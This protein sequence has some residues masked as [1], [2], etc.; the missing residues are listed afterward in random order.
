MPT[1]ARKSLGVVLILT[2]VVLIALAAWLGAMSLRDNIR[3]DLR[4]DGLTL[5]AQQEAAVEAWVDQFRPVAPVLAR[6]PRIVAMIADPTPVQVDAMNRE[7]EAITSLAGVDVTYILD[8][9]GTTLASSNWDR[10]VSF[11]GSNF[12]FRPYY[13]AAMQGR[14][15]R[16]FAV[17]TTSGERGYYLA[18][19]VRRQGRVIGAVVL[20]VP[21][22][23]LEQTMRLSEAPVFVSDGNGVIILAGD[24]RLRLTRLRDLTEAETD[25]IRQS[26]QYD[27]AALQPAAIVPEGRWFTGGDIVRTGQGGPRTEAGRFLWLKQPLAAEGWVLNILIDTAP[28]AR[29]LWGAAVIAGAVA[30]AVAAV[31]FVI[32]QRRRRLIAFSRA[33]ESQV[34]DRTALLSAEIA[35]RKATEQM[36]RR[37]QGELVQAGKLAALGQMSAA[38]SHEFNQPLTAIRTYAEN[39]TAF[40]E[41]GSRERATENLSRVMR[42]TER[43][44]QLSRHLTRFAR[45]S[46]DATSVVNLDEVIAEALGLLEGRIVRSEALVAVGG[47][48]G[49]TVWGGTVRLQHV[50]MNLVANAID[51]AGDAVPEIRITVQDAGEA[52]TLTVEDNGPGIPPEV[53]PQVFEPFFTT[54]EVGKGLGLGLSISYNIVQDFGGTMRAETIDG[55]GARFVVTLQGARHPAREAAE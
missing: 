37:T 20:K 32:L 33:L 5:I 18:A 40:I 34:V 26:R 17:G 1:T 47:D 21:V 41:A 51:A 9:E 22:A 10:D 8:R 16:F 48:T 44:A 54:K 43:M 45:R 24:P 23:R 52:V 12:A 15:G 38:L 53:L 49:V 46:Q 31:T 25:R 35:E 27:I 28:V 39:A 14:L 19:P 50:V 36:L 6:D 55:G 29:R 42:L 2:L 13:T 3:V 7:L 30:L 11:V 4:T